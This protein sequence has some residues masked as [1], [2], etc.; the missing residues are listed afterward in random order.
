MKRNLKIKNRLK[1]CDRKIHI[2]MQNDTPSEI[3]NDSIEDGIKCSSKRKFSTVY[4]LLK[5]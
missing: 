4:Y 2:Y 3:M 5:R 1:Y